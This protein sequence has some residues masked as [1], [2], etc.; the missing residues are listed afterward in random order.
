MFKYCESFLLEFETQ[1]DNV[2]CGYV[3]VF[4]FVESQ[5]TDR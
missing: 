2:L 3:V 4:R 1:E 5:R